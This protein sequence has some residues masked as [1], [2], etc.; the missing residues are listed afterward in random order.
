MTGLHAEAISETVAAVYSNVL[1]LAVKVGA[2]L[3]ET[4]TN[5]SITFLKG[6]REMQAEPLRSA[7]TV[8][9]RDKASGGI[10]KEAQH[11]R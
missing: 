7:N 4:D 9:L 11:G 8:V 10:R 6:A 1:D 5:P 3:D 2:E